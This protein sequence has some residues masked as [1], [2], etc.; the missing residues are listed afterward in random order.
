VSTSPGAKGGPPSTEE[1]WSAGDYDRLATYA[2]APEA[3]HLVR[4]A[5]VKSGQTVLDVGTGSGYVAVAA[6]QRGARVTGVDPTP[7][8]LAK[9]KENA[10]LAGVDAITWKEGTAENLPVADAS[11]DVVLSEFGHMFS[12]QPEAAAKEMLRVLKPGGRLAFAAWV[13]DGFV[14]EMFGLAARNMPPM[15][16][17]PP[18]SPLAWG[19]PEG[20]RKY[21]GSQVR[22]FRFEHAAL[23][24]P[25]LSPAHARRLM[26]EF[27]GP[28]LLLVRMLSSDPARLA[29]WRKEYDAIAASYLEDGRLRHEYLLTRATKA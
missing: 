18:P 24:L 8:L 28:T 11:F 5:G 15:P 20:V 14:G 4:F 25:A 26:E 6:A 3:T 12:P 22:D 21:L 17:P 10:A 7:L 9:A 13:P 1:L 16:G 27:F 2:T 23:V 19:Q 29:A